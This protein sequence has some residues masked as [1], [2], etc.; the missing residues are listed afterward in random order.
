M[1]EVIFVGTAFSF[2]LITLATWEVPTGWLQLGLG[3]ASLFILYRVLK[4]LVTAQ[5]RSMSIQ[6][7][8]STKQADAM[9]KLADATSRL[10]VR[11]ANLQ[12]EISSHVQ[13]DV[14]VQRAIAE[15]LE[16]LVDR[17]GRTPRRGNRMAVEDP[18]QE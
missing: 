13:A 1:N 3:G 12:A 10:D 6:A 18:P 14:E 16:V 7:E 9:S 15:N 8:A 4:P 11:F 17:V 2:P 5:T